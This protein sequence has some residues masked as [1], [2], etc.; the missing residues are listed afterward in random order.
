M[1][2][3]T[4]ALIII[5]VGILLYLANRYIPMEGTVKKILNIVVIVALVLWLL[6]TFGV[7]QI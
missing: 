4:I 3:V 1:P 2:I 5:A 7:I 6:R